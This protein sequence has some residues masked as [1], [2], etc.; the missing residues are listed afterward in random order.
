MKRTIE[1]VDLTGKKVF[2]RVD[3]NVPLGPNGN[4][5]DDKRII[6]ALPTIRYLLKEG[7]KLIICSH[8]GRPDGKVD[9]KFSLLPVAKRLVDLLTNKIYFAH[10]VVGED[11]MKKAE[12]LKSGE[13]LLLENVRFEQGE[14]INDPELAKKL[15]SMAEFFVNDA[16]GTAHRKHASTYG[17]AKLLPNAVGF[18]MGKEINT[19]QKALDNPERPFVA[20]V[21][22]AKVADKIGLLKN[23][24]KKV[25]VLL[26]GGGMAYTFLK[27]Q[28]KEIGMSLVDD[29]KIDIAKDILTTCENRGVKILLPVDSLCAKKFDA[30]SKA[31]VF[32]SNKFP[33][34][35]LGMDIGP[36]TIKTFC[37]EI[38]KARTA[39]WNGPMGVFEFA[40]FAKGTKKIAKAFA[41]V[42]GVTIVGGGDSA[43]AIKK[44]GLQRKITHISTGGG[45]SMML[46][47]GGSLPC[48]DVIS[49]L[50]EK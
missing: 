14:E 9:K 22:G 45:A 49:N 23:L 10:D 37:R 28:G 17:I 25:D 42:K 29:E 7:V 16:F 21:G 48:V 27:A 30:N 40:K 34:E 44:F 50:E 26:V 5:E 20:I 33:M 32:T 39:I 41:M 24:A 8:L 6:S 46:F 47:E 15:A 35:Y 13:V 12:N 1:N 38:G 3:F 31:K 2:L 43:L 4:I 18:L 36:K 19:I 11:A